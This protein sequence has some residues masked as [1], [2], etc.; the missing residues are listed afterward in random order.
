M[1][2]VLTQRGVEAARPKA[3]RYGIP[4]G[5]VPGL[6]LI[7]HAERHEE[8]TG[9]RPH[10]R[11][12]GPFTIGNAAVLT[13]A[14]AR[15]KGKRL[16]AEIADG[17][18]PRQTKQEAVRTASETVEIVARRF[19]ERHAKANNR[20]WKEVQRKLDVNVLP[21]GASGRSPRSP[22]AT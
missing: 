19:I 5:L 17:K 21:H 15:A 14:E 10:Q 11:P 7:V 20:T 13:L 6:Q 22:S 4:D 2:K 16:L 12:A 3:D 9:Y 18:D 1:A 8:R